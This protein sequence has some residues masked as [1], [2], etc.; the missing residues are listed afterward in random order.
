MILILGGTRSIFFALKIL[1]S[2]EWKIQ[3]STLNTSPDHNHHLFSYSVDVHELHTSIQERFPLYL[4]SHSEFSLPQIPMPS[5]GREIYISQKAGSKAG[6]VVE[7]CTPP[8]LLLFYLSHP[9]AY[10]LHSSLES[11]RATFSGNI[12]C[13]SFTWSACV[14]WTAWQL[15]HFFWENLGIIEQLESPT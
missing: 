12:N 2:R 1:G 9:M 7:Q 15:G 10:R 4:C 13:R 11:S 3:M 6:L 14:V 8:Q 5:S